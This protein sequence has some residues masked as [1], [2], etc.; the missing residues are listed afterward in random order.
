MR[1]VRT[2]MNGRMILGMTVVSAALAGLGCGGVKTSAAPP[3]DGVS[4]GATEDVYAVALSVGTKRD[5]PACTAAREGNVAHVN[6]PSGMWRCF[7]GAW[8]DIACASDQA[9]KVAYDSA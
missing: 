2:A 6:T 7:D 3:A 1:A 9:G 5:L 4:A 8:H